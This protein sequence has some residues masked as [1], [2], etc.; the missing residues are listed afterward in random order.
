MRSLKNY[1]AAL[2]QAKLSQIDWFDVLNNENI[3]EAWSIFSGKVLAVI[4]NIA[5]YK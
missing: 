5:P 3:N 4:D 1:S 2:F